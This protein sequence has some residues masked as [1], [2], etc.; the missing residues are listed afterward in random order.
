MAR[1]ENKSLFFTT[2]P[3]TPLKMIPE[4]RLLYE[5]FFNK[6]WN[7]EVQITFIDDLITSGFFE[8]NGSSKYKDFSARDRINRAPKAL[9]FIDLSPKID[10]TP[11]GKEFIYGRRP[12]EIFLRQL[13]KFQLPSPFHK[14][15]SQIEGTFYIKPYLEILR[16]IR[17]LQY[18]TFDELKVFALRLTDFRDY[19]LVKNN[20]TKF[21][22]KK[23]NY[24]G[25]YK[26]F[27]NDIWTNII[28]ETYKD[29]IYS[30]NTKIRETQD[31]SI[32]KFIITKKSN[33]R[34][35]A[36]ACF[37]YL[38]YTGLIAISNTNKSISIYKDKLRDVDYILSTVN[39]EPVF[40]DNEINYK[41]YLF[42]S[43]I[44]KLYVDNKLNI[45]DYILRISNYTK[46]Q[47]I[48]KDIE[49]L[50]NIKDDVVKQ[51]KDTVIKNQIYEI[52]SYSLYSEIIDTY[53]EIIANNYYDNPLML[54]YNTWRAMTMLN[55]GT[56][57][58]NFN[59]DDFGQPL[60]TAAGNMA[61]IEC[62]Y[63]DFILTVEVTMQQGQRQYEMEGEPVARHF[64]N[65]KKK[66]DKDTYCLFIAPTINNASLAHFYALNKIGISYYGGKTKIIPM[67]L[68]LFMLLVENAYNYKTQPKPNNIR[69]FLDKALK[70]EELSIDENDWYN[71][72]RMCTSEWLV[73]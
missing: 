49:E 58:G 56:I 48:D 42:D 33:D 5:K 53:N 65:I 54:E 11:A 70:Q 64:G 68:D 27:L 14:E 24:R 22:I 21:R 19:D 45:I 18:I 50:K 29:N 2:S 69:D 28:C 34:D 35:Y 32:K 40:V 44:P 26:K 15:N 4:I 60:S 13:L 63:E 30:G 6:K 12:Q 16:L 9:G 38:R 10:L 37:R 1:L 51:R 20:I 39:R 67:E 23:K 41:E 66:L 62:H 52:K 47:L 7:K 57:K 17:D 59:F 36:D 25:N 43:T 61:D 71:R 55:G 72:I 8:G 73:A 31:S 3:R 46:R